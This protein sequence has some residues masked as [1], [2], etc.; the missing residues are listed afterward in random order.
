MQSSIEKL[1]KF[2]RLEH[3]NGYTNTAV[4]GGLANDLSDEE[5]LEKLLELNMQ[6]AKG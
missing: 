1:R 5:V 2:F 4:I 6:R 3:E